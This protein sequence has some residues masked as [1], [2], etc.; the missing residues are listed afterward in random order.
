MASMEKADLQVLL[1][2]GLS[3]QQ[4]GVRV[5]A[6]PSTVAL[7]LK[8]HDLRTVSAAKFAP[9][10]GID[11]TLL[12][13]LVAEGLCLREIG[14]RC[15]VHLSTVR[16]WLNAYGLETPRMALLRSDLEDRPKYEQRRCRRHGP[17][18]F[19]RSAR[20]RYRCIRCRSERVAA[21]RRRVKQILV[22]EFGGRC[23]LCGYDRFAGALEFHHLDASTKSFSLAQ[24]GV[25]RSLARAR[26]EAGKC[27]LLC[28][29][30]HAEVEGGVA[31][32]P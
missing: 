22:E 7:W 18:R 27:V 23:R 9:K 30:C 19:V 21:R 24:G 20:G 5:G 3:L 2:E 25:A 29:N 4:I 8:K 13:E 12:E 31:A 10:G 14:E 28:S 32:P 1:G 15:G 26:A 17:T 16:Y 6:H 11:Q